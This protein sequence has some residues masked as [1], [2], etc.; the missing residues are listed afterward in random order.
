MKLLRSLLSRCR[1]KTIGKFDT[2]LIILSILLLAELFFTNK[3]KLHNSP[4]NA[5]REPTIVAT[6]D[7]NRSFH[8]LETG[9]SSDRHLSL[10]RT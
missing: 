6:C 5:R 9:G 8:V 10:W 2:G 3:P 4:T 1:F 7:E